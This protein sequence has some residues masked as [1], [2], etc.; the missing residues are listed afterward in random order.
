MLADSGVGGQVLT[1]HEVDLFA[2]ALYYVATVDGVDERETAVIKEFVSDAGFPELID[3]IEATGFRP[4]EAALVLQTSDKRRL[5]MKAL[6][7]L[8]KADGV[9]TQ[10][11]RLRMLSIADVLGLSQSLENIEDAVQRA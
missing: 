11:E 8:I 2:R 3:G 6:F 10:A 7:V 5:L 9:V 1:Q 4:E